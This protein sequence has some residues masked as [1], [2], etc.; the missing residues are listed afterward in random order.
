MSSDRT[1]AI[2]RRA[3]L[4]V[5]AIG[6]GGM[7]LAGCT[8]RAPEDELQVFAGGL[9]F[10]SEVAQPFTFGLVDRHGMS[11]EGEAASVRVAFAPVDGR[12]SRLEAVAS[13]QPFLTQSLR[14]VGGTDPRGYYLTT[15]TS[16]PPGLVDV[17]VDA[18][19]VRGMTTVEVRASPRAPVRGDPV[20][21]FDTPTTRQ[22]RGVERVCTR[23][24]ECGLHGS[25][26]KDL[27]ERPAPLVVV[28][29]SPLLCSS[30]MCGPVLEEA[31]AVR[32]ERPDV[33]FLHLEPYASLSTVDLAPVMGRWSLPSEP[34][35]FVIA[36]G[37]VQQRYEGPV[38]AA[39][40]TAALAE[41]D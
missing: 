34:W 5:S 36:E 38:R 37:V 35:T 19:G 18:D 40:M 9:E 2:D 32:R 17:L 39:A 10:L 13:W 1:R 22:S 30:R 33:S 4:R 20:I 31:L 21:V 29:G 28:V 24:P 7:L 25:T 14:D 26:L 23:D 6:I 16:M 41:L 12:G 27:L 3:F 15:M 11:F 8:R